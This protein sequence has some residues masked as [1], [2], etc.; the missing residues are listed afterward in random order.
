[1]IKRKLVILSTAALFGTAGIAGCGS[2]QEAT[3]PAANVAAAT[4]DGTT[5]AATTAAPASGATGTGA[6]AGQPPSG[7]PGGGTEVTGEAAT[8]ASAAALAKYPG[9]AD[10]VLQLEDGS[11]VVAVTTDE[12]RQHVLVTA[13][14]EVS[15]L[16]TKGPGAGGPTPGGQG[17]G[18]T[19]PAGA[20]PSTSTDS[21]AAP[22]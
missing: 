9:T 14:Y 8:K 6:G 12:G 22:S 10:H 16:D 17:S 21:A 5:G 19:P 2:T 20:A 4:N 3:T 15:G 18:G 13:G 11:F 1:M 7:A